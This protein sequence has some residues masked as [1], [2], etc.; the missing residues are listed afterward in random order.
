MPSLSPP[1]RVILLLLLAEALIAGVGPGQFAAAQVGGALTGTAVDSATGA[2]LTAARVHLV[3]LERR[4]DTHADGQFRFTAIPAGRYTLVVQRVGYRAARRTMSVGAEGLTGLVI[5][6]APAA[7]ELP[8]LVVTGSLRTQESETAIQP[9]SVLGGQKLDRVLAATL[10]EMLNHE[11]G[12][13]SVS[14][15]PASARP[16]IRGLGGD[17][18]LLL[19]DGART[20]DMSYSA[21]DHAVTTDPGSAERVEVVRGPAALLY[22]SNALSGV[23]NVI[24]DEIPTSRP[25]A[26]HGRFTL[27]GQSAA[28][29]S[30]AALTLTA[31]FAGLAVRAEGSA[32]TGGDLATPIGRLA[33]TQVRTLAGG[34]G[35]GVVRDWG[36]AG[37]AY[38]HYNSRY[39][40]PGGFVGGHDDGVTITMRRNALRGE[41]HRQMGGGFLTDLEAQGGLVHYAHE[42]LESGG[43]LG[44]AFRLVTADANL[45]ARH[46]RLGPAESGGAGLRAQFRDFAYGGSLRTPDAREYSG[47]FFLL[48]E[49]QTGRLRIQV[50][51]RYD[52]SHIAPLVADAAKPARSFGALSGSLGGLVELGRGVA[53]GMNLGR[54]FRTPDIND[55]YSDGPHLAAYREEVGNPALALE[56]GLGL[57]AFVRLNHERVRGELAVFQNRISQF[58]YP[59]ETGAI[60]QRGLPIAQY[61]GADARLEGAELKIVWTPAARLA[62]DATGSYVRGTLTDS[63]Q[64]LP[65]IPPL[66][67]TVGLRYERVTWFAGLAARLSVRQDRLGEFEE[68]TAGYQLIDAT[69]GFRWPWLGRLHAVTLRIDNLTNATWRDHL[70]LIKSIMPGPSRSLSVLYRAEF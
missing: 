44:T 28:R 68:V 34:V 29:S 12:V 46:G 2:P 20:G 5:R 40:I 35:A 25:E 7:I 39:G 42:E 47:A 3:E 53:I 43:A 65:L 45:M 41:L 54:A 30:L 57:D 63:A 19:E 58:V 18:V 27:H 8:G 14:M 24:R 52:W 17:R 15:G 9:V 49:H 13:A 62:V 21:S 69:G 11:A 48:E 36:H 31:P 23:I 38:R 61:T 10:G 22:G 16:I 59:R 67:G 4:T 51:A 33:N 70:S 55:L 56:Q 32:R 66:R 26:L 60:S 50:G 37:G 6:L 1:I 64:P